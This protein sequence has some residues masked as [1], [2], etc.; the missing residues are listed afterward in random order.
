MDSED[1]INGFLEVGQFFKNLSL[2]SV[3]EGSEIV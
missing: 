1:W 3:A 2:G